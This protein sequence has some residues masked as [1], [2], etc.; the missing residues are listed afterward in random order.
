MTHGSAWKRSSPVLVVLT[1]L[2]LGHSVPVAGQESANARYAFP[3]S[4]G[5]AYQPLSPIGAVQ[6]RATVNAL[7]GSFHLPLPMLPYLQPFVTAGVAT[8]DSVE[9]DDPTILGGT[10]DAGASMPPYDQQTVWDHQ[11]WFGGVGISYAH[12]ISKEFEVGASALFAIG[13]SYFPRRVVTSAGEW[14]PIGSLGLSLGASGKLSLDPSYHLSIDV[15]PTFR[16]DLTFGSLPDFDGLYFGIGFAGHYRFGQD[17]DAPQARV[18]ALEFE[19][20]DMPPAFAAMQKVYVREPLFSVRVRNT[21]SGVVENL[22][23]SFYQAGFMDSPTDSAEVESIGSGEQ[24]ELPLLASF[25]QEVFY[26]SGVV[27]LNGEIIAE[28]TYRGQP[29]EQRRSVTFDLLDRNAIAWDRDE[30]VAALITPQDSAVRNFASFVIESSEE[31]E[32]DYLPGGVETAMQVYHALAAVEI[33][34]QPDPAS[35]FAVVHGDPLAVDTVSLPRETLQRGTGDCDDIT[36][37]FNAMLE[38]VNVSTGIVTIPGHIYAA[39]DTGLS[40]REYR[41]VHPDRDMTL[42]FDESLWVLIEITMIGE[43]GFVDAWETGMREWHQYDGDESSRAIY[44]TAECQREFQ[45]VGLRETDIGLQYG[46]PE[47]FLAP[48]RRDLDQVAEL[49]LRPML[50]EATDRNSPRVW[51]HLGIAAA[52]FRKY[53]HAAQAF[54]AAAELDADYLSPRVNLGSVLYLQEDHHGARAAF[55]T[56]AAL[57]EDRHEPSTVKLPIYVNLA[58]T[59]HALE[60]YGDA[61]TYLA[62]AEAID[63][64]EAAKYQYTA[65]VGTA[66]G[67]AAAAELTQI[68]FIDD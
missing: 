33:G 54:L 40:P 8:Y 38:S 28:Y 1:A 15:M 34:Y 45:P 5:A 39:V 23:L 24:I 3:F 19:V 41:T 42:A 9:L 10:L 66:G 65:S 63:S 67:R 58:K 35:P 13:Q 17:P 50:D 60:M 37:L 12:R 29:V 7:S 11:N 18:R 44:S 47:A 16:Y 51:N 26:T 6:R 20:P 62:Q 48:Y 4:I 2:I 25:N 32:T 21:E 56:A 31:T 64:A 14:Y 36:V 53:E 59:C 49:F 46:D 57:A 30:K 61:A 22:R 52:R 27:P 43:A 68:L 55:E